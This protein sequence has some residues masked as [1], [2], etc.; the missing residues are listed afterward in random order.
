MRKTFTAPRRIMMVSCHR[1][2]SHITGPLWGESTSH[3]WIPLTKGRWCRAFIL[4]ILLAPTSCWT[5]WLVAGDLGYHEAHVTSLLSESI[6]F[7]DNDKLWYSI[8]H[9]QIEARQNGHHVANNIL[10][11]ILL[12]K[13]FIFFIQIS[14]KFIPKGLI[15]HKLALY[16]IATCH[17]TCGKP[18]S[19]LMM[20]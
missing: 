7:F 2:T 8:K 5:N 4:Y 16:Q 10:K 3:R 17:W 18:S 1:N 20:A 9:Q 11:C 15:K 19:E 12:D 14:L 13:K 6:I